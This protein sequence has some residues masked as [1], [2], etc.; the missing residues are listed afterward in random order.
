MKKLLYAIACLLAR[1]RSFFAHPVASSKTGKTR[2]WHDTLKTHEFYA[3]T[4]DG[5]LVVII[6]YTEFWFSRLQFGNG[7]TRGKVEYQ[8]EDERPVKKIDRTT[9]EIVEEDGTVIT[10]KSLKK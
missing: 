10:V 4:E 2:E 5:E 1:V 9:Y 8:T 7:L 3:E 6:E